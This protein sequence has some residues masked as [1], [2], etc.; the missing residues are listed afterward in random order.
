MNLD[1]I[2]SEALLTALISAGCVGGLVSLGSTV[3]KG[4][5]A[6][7]VGG[8]LA[9]TAVQYQIDKKRTEESVKL[10]MGEVVHRIMHSR[11]LLG[12]KYPEP[13]DEDVENEKNRYLSREL[14]NSLVVMMGIGATLA[15]GTYLPMP[16][17]MIVQP[18]IEAAAGQIPHHDH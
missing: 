16:A 12:E 18:M 11:T 6:G 10:S 2:E 9:G 7:I 14:M 4:S 13:T 1:I 15:I 3:S 17:Q 8:V 5:V